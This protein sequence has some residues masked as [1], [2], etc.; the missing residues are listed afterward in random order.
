MPVLSHAAVLFL[1]RAHEAAQPLTLQ[2][3]L[4]CRLDQRGRASD[5][6]QRLLLPVCH[7]AA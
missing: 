2:A 6:N 1:P 7:S 5:D 4:P 3:V